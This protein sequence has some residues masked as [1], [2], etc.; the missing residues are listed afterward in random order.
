MNYRIFTY[1]ILFVTTLLTLFSIKGNLKRETQDNLYPS[2]LVVTE[3]DNN[4]DEVIITDCNGFIY[5]FNGIEDW[6]IGDTVAVI[7]S[8]NGTENNILDDKIIDVKYSCF[9]EN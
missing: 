1:L 5:C 3:I 8:D 6:E 2:V 4:S 7:F 9:T